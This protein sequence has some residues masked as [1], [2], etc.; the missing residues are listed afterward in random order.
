M[1]AMVHFL[2]PQVYQFF[3]SLYWH[4]KKSTRAT[5][6]KLGHFYVSFTIPGKNEEPSF[7]FVFVNETM[8]KRQAPAIWERFN[9]E[10]QKRNN[11]RTSELNNPQSQKYRPA[12][13][14]HFAWYNRTS[15]DQTGHFGRSQG[16]GSGSFWRRIRWSPFFNSPPCHLKGES[17][18]PPRRG[19]GSRWG[20]R[21]PSWPWQPLSWGGPCRWWGWEDKQG[22]FWA[23]A[24][25]RNYALN[26]DRICANH[27][28]KWKVSLL[29]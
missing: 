22:F 29:C 7:V 24:G 15:W 8:L 23:A 17:G 10:K 12:V 2:W 25:L 3:S 26:L 13:L 28:W 27:L 4:N 19:G 18:W 5:V 9:E 11:S 16:G 1:E 21:R 6:I 20:Q 14:R